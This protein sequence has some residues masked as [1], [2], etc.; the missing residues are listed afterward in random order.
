MNTPGEVSGCW[1]QWAHCTQKLASENR[2]LRELISEMAAH[3][4]DTTDE[5]K[6]VGG[7]EEANP[8]GPYWI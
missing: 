1:F 8:N 7:A 5:L 2:Q 3:K 6:L 4:N